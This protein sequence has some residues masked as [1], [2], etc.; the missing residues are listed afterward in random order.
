[1]QSAR[2][3][4]FCIVGQSVYDCTLVLVETY[5]GG[6]A[7]QHG[8][9]QEKTLHRVLSR[10]LVGTHKKDF[11]VRSQYDVILRLPAGGR[12]KRELRRRLS[13]FTLVRVMESVTNE[14]AVRQRLRAMRH[15][16]KEPAV[17]AVA[18]DEMSKLR[19]C[20]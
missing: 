4:I 13:K 1:M 2:L 10:L 20:N 8:V 7:L 6:V 15:S 9:L 17:T 11:L 3:N 18:K 16:C 12:L 19:T 14:N 5:L